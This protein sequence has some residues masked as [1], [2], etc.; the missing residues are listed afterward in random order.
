[1]LPPTGKMLSVLFYP[2]KG[3]IKNYNPFYLISFYDYFWLVIHNYYDFCI[4]LTFIL[5]S[6]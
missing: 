6:S 5:Y 4:S 3:K 1:M 2:R